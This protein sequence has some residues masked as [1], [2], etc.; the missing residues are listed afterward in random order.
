MTSYPDTSFLFRLYDTELESAKAI[1]YISTLNTSLVLCGLQH[2]EFTQ[3][4]RLRMFR[5][6]S[7]RKE[8]LSRSIGTKI[9]NEFSND[10]HKNFFRFIT[11]DFNE[12]LKFSETISARHTRENG[13]RSLDILHV[14]AALHIGATD[15]LTFDKSQAVLAKAEGLATPMQ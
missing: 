10:L 13:Y 15:F 9:L 12:I 11:A 6:N 5:Y 3:A 2:F 7:D 14:A 8:G 1:N 4:I